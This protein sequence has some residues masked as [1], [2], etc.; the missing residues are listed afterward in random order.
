MRDKNEIDKNEIDDNKIRI[1]EGRRKISSMFVPT[2]FAQPFKNEDDDFEDDKPKAHKA[3]AQRE[4]V[5]SRKRLYLR[6]LVVSLLIFLMAVVVLIYAIR[7]GRNQLMQQNASQTYHSSITN[8][9]PAAGKDKS[10]AAPATFSDPKEPGFTEVRD[11]VINGRGLSLLIP[12]NAVP[13]LEVGMDVMDDTEAVLLLQAADVRGDNG[14]INCAFVRRGEM[15]TRGD[16][17]AGFCAII[18]GHVS[19]GVERYSPLLEEAIERQ[20]DFFRQY[21][22]VSGGLPVSNELH[23]KALRRALVQQNGETFAVLSKDRMTLDEFASLLTAL[24]AEQAIYLVGSK[25]FASYRTEDG[26][27]V[28]LGNRH[29]WENINFI[30]WH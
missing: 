20:G 15:L 29:E 28:N 11:T 5:P 7:V 25:A 9:A 1:I 6:W 19:V 13:S 2:E 12:H 24:G 16:R 17:K 22:L 23:N 10:S 30:V 4:G 3:S 27:Y 8:G 18:D 21:P 26:T 14:K